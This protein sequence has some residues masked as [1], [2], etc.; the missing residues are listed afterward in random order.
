MVLVS[1]LKRITN[2]FQLKS[3]LK[4]V[5]TRT[6]PNKCHK[7]KERLHSFSIKNNTIMTAI[8]FKAGKLPRFH[9]QGFGHFWVIKFPLEP[10]H[11]CY[12][13]LLAFEI[14]WPAL[15]MFFYTIRWWANRSIKQFFHY[16]SSYHKHY[17]F[18]I[19]IICIRNESV[20]PNICQCDVW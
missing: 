4:T 20:Q 6:R 8:I 16:D 15:G 5:S 9:L 17:C 14:H 19:Q 3:R 18:N 11:V 7:K 13:T 1:K 10:F 12:Y 2:L